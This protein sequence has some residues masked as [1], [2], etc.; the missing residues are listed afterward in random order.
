MTETATVAGGPL[1][2]LRVVH[3]IVTELAVIEV[4]HDGLRLL[5]VAS[6]SSVEAVRAATGTELIVGQSVGRF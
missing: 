3:L 6:D 2:G 1:T 4:A 5:E